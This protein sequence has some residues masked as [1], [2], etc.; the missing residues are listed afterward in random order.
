M[1]NHDETTMTRYTA[2]MTKPIHAGNGRKPRIKLDG[3]PLPPRESILEVKGNH[4]SA[5]IVRHLPE[6]SLIGA[7]RARLFEVSIP[8]QAGLVELQELLALRPR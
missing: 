4:G 8:L 6:T 1:R 5:S 3:Q 2:P 7:L